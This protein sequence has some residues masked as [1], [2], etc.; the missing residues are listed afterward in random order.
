MIDLTKQS[1]L[2]IAFDEQ[3]L[4][5]HFKEEFPR[6]Q[7]SQR[8]LKDLSPYLKNQNLSFPDLVYTVWR[9]VHKAE[10]EQ[11]ISENKLR[12]DLTLLPQGLLGDEFLRTA[13][14]FHPLSPD[15][16]LTAPEVYE[17]ILGQGGFLIQDFRDVPENVENVFLIIAHASEKVLVPP[18]FGHITINLSSRP[19]LVANWISDIT[20]YNYEPFQKNHGGAY[21]IIK[22]P[23]GS[24]SPILN[25]N[26]QR[27]PGIK[28]ITAQD[29]PQFGLVKET[30]MYSLVENLDKLRFLNYPEEFAGVW[31]EH[32]KSIS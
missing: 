18:G 6:L 25:P 8:A 32:L 31:S 24:I 14:H 1:G 30:P 2:A 10:D 11:K 29:W 3:N 15:A 4:D 23:A 12:Y 5:L 21:W 7:K 22:D 19:L 26:Y 20:S 17:V 9:Y 28:K 27:V 16:S 13:G